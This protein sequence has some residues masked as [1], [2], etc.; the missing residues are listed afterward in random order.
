MK[1]GSRHGSL[2]ISG[3]LTAAVAALTAAPAAAQQTPPEEIIV[4]SSIVTQP[5]RQIGTAVGVIESEEIELRGYDGLAEILR[6]QTGIGVTNSGG[7]GK[8]TAVSIR[9]EDSFRTLLMID[10][11]KALDP[12]GPQAVPHFDSLVTTGDLQRVEVLRGPQGFIYGADA[13]GVVNVITQRGADDF[14]GRVGVEIGDYSMR[15][16]EAALSG[17]GDRGDFF[18]SAVDLT[19]DGFNAR[20]DDTVLQD[21]DGAENTTLHTKLGWN[22]TDAVRLQFVARD[23]DAEAQYDACGFFSPQHDCVTTTE[24]MTYKL[25]ADVTG[26]LFS[27]S[28]GYSDVDIERDNFAG[29]RSTFP[30]QGGLARLEYTGSYKPSD[31]LKLVYGVDLQDEELTAPDGFRSRDQDGYYFE[32]QGAFGNAF[33]M[34]LGARY[35]DNETFGSHTSSRLSVAYVQDLRSDRSLKYRASVGNGFRAPSLYE[36]AYNFGLFASPPAAGVMLTEETSEGYDIGIEYEAGRWHFEAT[37]FDQEIEDAI[38]FDLAAFSGYLQT[39]GVSTSTGVEVAADVSLGEH[40]QLLANWTYND[41]KDAAGEQRLRRPKNLGN[42]GLQYRAVNERLRFLANYRLSSDAVDTNFFNTV[43]LPDYEILDLSV[44]FDA[45]DVL[46]L[47]GRVQNAAD[48]SYTEVLGYNT[49][50]RSVYGGVRLRF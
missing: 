14:G 16:A 48:E 40:W 26:D 7:P 25:S 11:V 17:G 22:V 23:I 32:Y 3:S 27:S 13:G 8:F 44:A 35:D 49:A 45:S 6:T 24:Q 39:Q 21:D 34:S 1:A 43:S 28:F 20:T 5:R 29:G 37:Y 31:L 2:T 47:Y 46:Q 4:T 41:A 38:E 30:T 50:E 33:F 10:G 42:V 18:V 36:S 19:T 12:S 15:K 9:G